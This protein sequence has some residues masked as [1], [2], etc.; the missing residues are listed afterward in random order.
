MKKYKVTFYI[1][2]SPQVSLII[3]VLDIN[4]LTWFIDRFYPDTNWDY[5]VME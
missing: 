4:S 2:N 5:E 1:S 3:E